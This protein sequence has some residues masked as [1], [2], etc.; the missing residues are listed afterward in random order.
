MH[1]IQ[2]NN[3]HNMNDENLKLNS[4]YINNINEEFI[5]YASLKKNAIN[6][7]MIIKQEIKDKKKN[8]KFKKLIFEIKNNI[9]KKNIFHS[10]Y[11]SSI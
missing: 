11:I 4:A 9:V 7:I 10:S 8:K 6:E 1:E 5:W 3:Y 2:K